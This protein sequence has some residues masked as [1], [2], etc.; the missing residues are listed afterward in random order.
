MSIWIRRRQFI[1]ALG[2]A[3]AWRRGP[4]C[5]SPVGIRPSSSPLAFALVAYGFTVFVA[6]RASVW[7]Q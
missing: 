6:V 1:A 4:P 5:G 2:G 7:R 3:A